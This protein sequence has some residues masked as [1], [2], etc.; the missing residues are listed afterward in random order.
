MRIGI[1]YPQPFAD[2]PDWLDTLVAFARRVENLEFATLWLPHILS[3]DAIAAAAVVG[4][5]TEEIELA[6]AVVPTYPRHPV[7]MAQQAMTAASACNGRFTLGIGTSH[8]FIMEDIHGL[9]FAKPARHTEE[10]LNVLAPLLR[11]DAVDFKGDFYQVKAD[12]VFPSKPLVPLIVAAMGPMMLERAGRL[13]DG[14]VTFATGIKTLG[15]YIVPTIRQ[16][17]AAAGREA[18]RIIASLVI[19]LTND[20]D[21]AKAKL[22]K[23]M[24]V[25]DS[26]PSYRAMLDREGAQGPA[27]IALL[28]D[29]AA[30]RA[31]LVR[32]RAAGVTDF[33]ASP[34]ETDA[35]S[36]ERTL[37]FLASEA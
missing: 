8:R 2:K 25:Y 13:S 17:A 18:P 27:D 29:E 6:T 7:A 36:M 11:G 20:I 12:L 21:G 32:M 31:Q 33:N 3:W 14:T 23:R 4:R 30:L 9:S 22:R 24:R 34:V 28:G 26:I 5:E 35:G 37:E 10:Y 19:S 1:A 15:D 16:A